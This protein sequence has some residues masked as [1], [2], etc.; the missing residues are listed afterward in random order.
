MTIA[1]KIENRVSLIDYGTVFS[2][3]D[4]GLPKEWWENIRV[5]LSRMIEKGQIQ[6]LSKGRFYKP[7]ATVFGLLKPN[8]RETVK[9]LIYD[10]EGKQIGYITGQSIWSDMFLTTQ[11]SNVIFIGTNKRH[12]PVKRG[13][14]SIRFVL[15]PNAITKENINLLQILDTIRFIK[16]IPD[17]TVVNSIIVLKSTIGKL[18]KC[19][20][21]KL[22]QLSEKYQPRV[23]AI[24]GAILDDLD[25]VKLT[26]KLHNKL[27]P[28]T[29]YK[30][31]LGG[32]NELHH[33][34]KWNIE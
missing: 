9:D 29:K 19:D 32:S 28:G 7:Q 3:H 12:N 21:I 5:K 23:M 1:Q 10:R 13:Q 8:M 34:D 6:K 26:S 22:L 14:F 15:Q 18:K 20:I 11:V 31:G 25:Y 2:I 24:L 33:K 30:L 4:L 17:T 16:E 27:N